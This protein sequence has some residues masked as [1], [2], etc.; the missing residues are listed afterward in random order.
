MNSG[1]EI[2]AV[3]IRAVD[4]ADDA[5]LAAWHTVVTTAQLH[6]QTDPLL[7]PL[8]E[9]TA[10]FRDRNA[11]RRVELLIAVEDGAVVGAAEVTMPTR[12]NLTLAEADIAVVPDCRRRGIGSALFDRIVAICR[13]AG[14]TS[15]MAGVVGP[16]QDGPTPPGVPFAE[17]YGLTKRNE[18]VRRR[19]TLPV[20]VDRLDEL[21]ASTEPHRADYRL[22]HWE[23]PCPDEY[24]EQYA[25]L[26]PL[27]SVEAPSG[28]LEFEPE[29]YDVKRLRDGEQL[30]LAQGR[31]WFTT[32]A[33]ASDGALAGHTQLSV[34]SSEHDAVHA[35]QWATLV[36][37]AHRGHRLGLALKAFNHR[38]AQEAIPDLN[39]TVHTWN[40][41]QN[42]WMI[43][44]NEALG[45]RPVDVY[46]EF[47]GDL[48]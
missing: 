31:R 14:R 28:D 24:V 45:Y 22:E 47:Q 34:P 30:S 13:P 16:Y 4:I 25:A 15:L 36:V 5:D 41:R 37:P 26:Q 21:L 18:E 43:Q 19:L 46:Q 12:D 1:V 23:G 38:F 44:V 2:R 20:P 27:L 48:V 11:P 39:R 10:Y 29:V 7:W 33:V 35:Y 9:L 3:D 32:I 6:D 17:R 42:S 40:A 8:A